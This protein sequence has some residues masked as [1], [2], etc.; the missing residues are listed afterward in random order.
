MS[1]ASCTWALVF[2]ACRNVL[3]QD[4]HSFEN[5]W[6]PAIACVGLLDLLI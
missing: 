1:E 5:E 4:V 6:L 3:G 2:I